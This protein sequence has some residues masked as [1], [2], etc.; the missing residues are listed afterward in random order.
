MHFDSLS[1]FSGVDTDGKQ[2][3]RWVTKMK[4]LL[5][6]SGLKPASY[7]N[8]VISHLTDDAG[9]FQI[10]GIPPGRVQV[11]AR[12]EGYAAATTER[13]FVAAGGTREDL[14]L[15]LEPAGHLAGRVIDEREVGVE[16]VLVEVR[17]DR[18]PHARVAL[19]DV[20]GRFEM[21]SVVG[22]HWNEYLGAA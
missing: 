8:K 9:R 17:S 7:A 18:E 21:A 4:R 2:R 14:E 1:K 10:A 12:R 19:T 15:V 6:S 11:I 22:D 16:A 5:Y 3:K 20:E 13:L